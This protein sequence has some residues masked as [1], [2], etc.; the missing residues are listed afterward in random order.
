VRGPA[1]EY[2]RSDE[3]ASGAIEKKRMNADEHFPA[4]AVGE[5]R[6][7]GHDVRTVQED[8]HAG[9]AGLG[10]TQARY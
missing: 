4:P 2:P 1:N 3:F 5:L 10:D 7:L 9:L 6:A 8:G